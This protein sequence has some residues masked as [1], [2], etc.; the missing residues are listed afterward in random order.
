MT[1]RF[2][3]SFLQNVFRHMRSWRVVLI[4]VALALAAAVA[5]QPYRDRRNNFQEDSYGKV[6]RWTDDGQIEY[7]WPVWD[8]VY[9]ECIIIGLGT[10]AAISLGSRAAQRL[11]RPQKMV[12][13]A[14]LGALLLTCLYPP[15][16]YTDRSNMPKPGEVHAYQAW[17]GIWRDGKPLLPPSVQA[18]RFILADY[19]EVRWRCLMLQWA[20]IVVIAVG[21]LA[22]LRRRTLRT[23]KPRVAVSP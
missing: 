15:V 7:W 9:L 11:R 14:S 10:G 21:G 19:N 4:L 16:Y 6:Y 18:D 22:S 8:R 23:A 13:A 20:G 3:G 1:T 2:D 12:L 5:E 17:D